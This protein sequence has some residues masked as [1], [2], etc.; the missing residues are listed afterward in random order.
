MHFNSI[1]LIDFHR[2]L[3]SGHCTFFV[4]QRIIDNET[5]KIKGF[6]MDTIAPVRERLKILAGVVN[7][8]DLELNGA[9]RKLMHA[10][11]EKPILSRPQHE[12]Y[13]VKFHGWY[14]EF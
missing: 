8:E 2:V 7:I 12:F 14:L 11:N 6:P 1:L 13:S 3:L 5:E 9:E 4:N 10:Y